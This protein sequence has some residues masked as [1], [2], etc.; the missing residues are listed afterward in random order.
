MHAT[1]R[2]D[3]IAV[4]GNVEGM[5]SIR[6]HPQLNLE[7]REGNF[8]DRLTVQRDGQQRQFD[9]DSQYDGGGLIPRDAFPDSTPLHEIDRWTD[10]ELELAARF[11]DKA[12][13]RRFYVDGLIKAVNGDLNVTLA[14]AERR[15]HDDDNN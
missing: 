5:W 6:E 2:V 10:R 3:T 11:T 7:W 1:K 12:Q 9:E 8:A 13:Q 4:R 15:F 14:E